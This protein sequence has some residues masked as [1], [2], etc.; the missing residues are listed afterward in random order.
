MKERTKDVVDPLSLF[1]FIL[2]VLF[3]TGN[4]LHHDVL[5]RFVGGAAPPSRC[6]SLLT[7]I[8]VGVSVKS[9]AAQGFSGR[10]Q[11]DKQ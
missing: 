11:S 7:V 3:I 4:E 8:V 2:A 9:L 5:K 10:R 6:V 1:L